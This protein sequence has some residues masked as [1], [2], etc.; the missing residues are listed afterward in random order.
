MPKK[1]AVE[2]LARKMANLSPETK[3]I[4]VDYAQRI[5]NEEQ[6]WKTTA[7]LGQQVDI[8]PNVGTALKQ[9]ETTLSNALETTNNFDRRLVQMFGEARANSLVRLAY[10]MARLSTAFVPPMSL[11][12]LPGSLEELPEWKRS[13]QF[14][15]GQAL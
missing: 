14:R 6:L 10:R 5:K 13:I 3:D 15:S 2:R 1:G 8:N 12:G 9:T 7:K 4:V 11:F